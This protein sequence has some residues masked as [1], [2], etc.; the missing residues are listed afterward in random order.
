MEP[1]TS[2]HSSNLLTFMFS[3]RTGPSF[4]QLRRI[5]SYL[6][7]RKHEIDNEKK[8]KSLT[9]R[10]VGSFRPA[11]NTRVSTP[12]KHRSQETRSKNV[13]RYLLHSRSQ[14]EVS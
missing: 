10:R 3:P 9:R 1:I 4:H 5:P 11:S 12:T 2:P 6:V 7:I 14:V 13:L 8:L